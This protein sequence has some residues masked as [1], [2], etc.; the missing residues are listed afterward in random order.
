MNQTAQTGPAQDHD[1][2]RGRN[3]IE[4]RLCLGEVF[5]SLIAG[6]SPG[7]PG[8]DLVLDRIERMP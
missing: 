8:L 5:Q 6:L 2:D 1:Q 4:P 7:G 3:R